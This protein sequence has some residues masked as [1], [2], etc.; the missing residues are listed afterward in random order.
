MPS[1]FTFQ[2]GAEP[3]ANDASDGAP[4]LGRFR[5]VPDVQRHGRRSHR[6]SLLNRL[7]GAGL[8]GGFGSL[9]D[10]D[11]EGAVVEGQDGL[12]WFTRQARALRDLYLEPKHYSVA[13]VVE[14]WWSRWLV[15][16]VL[17]AALVSCT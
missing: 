13:K 3:R 4:L 6:N 10:G 16:I 14:V 8:Y 12:W 7:S 5:A 17:P 11:G 15:L 2:Q 1:F 9:G